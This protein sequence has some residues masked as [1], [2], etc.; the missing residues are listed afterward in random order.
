MLMNTYHKSHE[1]GLEILKHLNDFGVEYNIRNRDNWTPFHFA[2]KRG[3]LTA[4][5]AMLE[6]AGNKT[7]KSWLAAKTQNP[8]YVDVDA[9]GGVNNVTALHLATEN[10]YYD[11]VDLLF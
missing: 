7:Q 11:I 9:M 5:K 3:N 4:I 8:N 6:I 1:S 10:N 2:V